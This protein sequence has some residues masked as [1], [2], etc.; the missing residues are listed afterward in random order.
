[1][2]STMTS[3]MTSLTLKCN[4]CAPAAGPTGCP[5]R[6][7]PRVQAEAGEGGATSTPMVAN[8]RSEPPQRLGVNI[9]CGADAAFPDSLACIRI[10]TQIVPV[11][12]TSAVKMTA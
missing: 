6:N 9:P 2:T 4:R 11:V 10:N 12:I 1:M 5:R 7:S 3:M 8:S